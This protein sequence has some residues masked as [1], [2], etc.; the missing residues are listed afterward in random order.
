MVQESKSEVDLRSIIV[1]KLKKYLPIQQFE[2][3]QVLI[4]P[5][6][7]GLHRLLFDTVVDQGFSDNQK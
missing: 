2:I 4:N 1:Q 6:L 3:I 5:G 7:D